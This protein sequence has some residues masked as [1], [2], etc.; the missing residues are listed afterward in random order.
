MLRASSSS[1]RRLVAT[2][3]IPFIVAPTGTMANNGAITLGT[4]LNATYAN[5]YIYLPAG[6][7]AAGVPAAA[8]WFFCQMSSATLGTV[9]NNTYTSGIPTI[10]ASPT[11]FVTTGPGAYVGVTS[12]AQ[13][14]AFSIPGNTLGPNGSIEYEATWSYNNSAGTK[15]CAISYGS[16]VIFTSTP[17][18]TVSQTI[19]K[20]LQNRAATN[21]QVGESSNANFGSG[22]AAGAPVYS[23]IDTTAAQNIFA[24]MTLATAT[25]FVVLERFL[26][27]VVQA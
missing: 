21:A 13:A 15:T 8:T 14:I 23:S 24:S 18:T 20:A 17:S 2:S 5:A 1:S 7:I 16:A 27:E 10:P 9:F 3:A 25:D 11:A 22:T 26:V 4:A 19:R 12:S 6:A